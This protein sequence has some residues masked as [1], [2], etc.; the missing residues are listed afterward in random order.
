MFKSGY[1]LMLFQILENDV[2]DFL[3][4]IPLEYYL[5]DKRS[6]I[7]SP[8]LAELLI[9]I[10][11]QIDI[12]FRNWS[13]V[14]QNN[15]TKKTEELTFQNYKSINN[16]YRLEEKEIKILA[17]DEIIKPFENWTKRD[18]NWWAS[19][20]NVKHNGFFHKKEGNLINVIESLAALF[21]LNCLHEETENKLIKYGY[22]QIY[23]RV[24][25]P[26]YFTISSQLFGIPP[27]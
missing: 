16:V 5:G 9:R 25:A 14:Q 13:V 6:E 20:N 12:Y 11:S 7:Y 24:E 8:R 18:P 1:T 26:S 22:K 27:L 23:S 19:Y 15:P 2:V 21:L 4:Y 10:G 3:T 17:T